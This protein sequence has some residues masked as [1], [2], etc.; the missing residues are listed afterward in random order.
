[1]GEGTQNLTKI[2]W[3]FSWR[4]L[5]SS[6]HAICSLADPPAVGSGAPDTWRVEGQ[7]KIACRNRWS[8]AIH[9][10]YTS[11]DEILTI[12]KSLPQGDNA[13]KLNT[14]LRQVISTYRVDVWRLT[15]EDFI[16]EA[17]SSGQDLLWQL[18]D[19]VLG[20]LLKLVPLQAWQRLTDRGPQFDLTWL[21][22][23]RMGGKIHES[24]LSF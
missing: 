5:S 14:L 12:I 20:E 10:L 16:D 15:R 7:F 22:R 9:L 11:I 1:M 18:T 19:E 17:L 3:M 4:L 13:L 8:T 24:E 2:L 21:R 23:K 6:H